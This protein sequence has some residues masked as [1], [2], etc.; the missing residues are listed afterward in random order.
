MK[1]LI[2]L[3]LFLLFSLSLYAV[4]TG[5]IQFNVH[6]NINNIK[7][8]TITL[9]P[10]SG[11]GVLPEDQQGR[12]L[13]GIVP[14]SESALYNVCLIKYTT[15]EKGTHKVAFSA[16]PLVNTDTLDE[17]PYKLYITYSNSFPVELEVNPQDPDNS[18]SID[19]V[20]YGA[21]DT[22]IKIY[23]DA[24]ITNYLTMAIGDYS[25]VISIER[26]SV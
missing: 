8:T 21:G 14:D 26:I 3:L 17:E 13:Q 25:S 12:K 10:Y 2:G 5:N 18:K 11:S 1:K 24:M 4:S 16:T 7:T 22:T 9:L 15:N 20:V 19:F 23:L 6:W